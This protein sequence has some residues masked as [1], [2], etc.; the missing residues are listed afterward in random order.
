MIVYDA[1]HV[2]SASGASPPA[3]QVTAA[4]AD[5]ASRTADLGGT[6]RSR[7]EG[8]I[9]SGRDPS[10]LED[11]KIETASVG[12]SSDLIFMAKGLAFEAD[13]RKG[14]DGQLSVAFEIGAKFPSSA[15]DGRPVIFNLESASQRLVDGQTHQLILDDKLGSGQQLLVELY[16]TILRSDGSRLMEDDVVVKKWSRR[17]RAVFE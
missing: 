16:P 1:V 17:W 5:P 4:L 2:V 13:C 10:C 14:D 15:T 8:G 6:G 7:V 3:G 11:P 9:G 12:L